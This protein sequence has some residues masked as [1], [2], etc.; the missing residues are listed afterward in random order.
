MFATAGC[1]VLSGIFSRL[2][3]PEPDTGQAGRSAFPIGIAKRYF[4]RSSHP[5]EE[6]RSF[7]AGGIG[8]LDLSL[9]SSDLKI[10]ASTTPEITLEFSSSE[11]RTVTAETASTTI[12]I[13][14]QTGG[15][16]GF[17]GGGA[18]S[19][20]SEVVLR[21]PPGVRKVRI[22]TVSGGVRLNGL[23]L[24]RLDLETISGDVLVS[25]AVADTEARSTSG[26][27][28]FEQRN[29]VPHMRLSTTSGDAYLTFG[30][31]LD[32][33]LD[34]SSTSGEAFFSRPEG[35]QDHRDR[36]FDQKIGN[37]RGDVHIKTVSGDAR[38]EV[39]SSEL[40]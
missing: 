21:L 9:V 28:R 12:R 15:N 22:K 1:F 27:L 4:G 2:A 8:E 17:F 20:E 23:T 5:V 33:K 18:D 13:L 14:E 37:G 19:G 3:G 32:A 36:N 30:R 39:L 11:N 10:E 16:P 38:I 31:N 25:A 6:K 7:P 35:G 24:D 40:R 26:E 29:P 34:F